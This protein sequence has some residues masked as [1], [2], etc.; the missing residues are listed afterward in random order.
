MGI[1]FQCEHCQHGLNLKSE[2]AGRRGICPKC[3]GKFRIPIDSITSSTDA[4]SALLES[5]ASSSGEGLSELLPAEA[6]DPPVSAGLYWVC[7]PSGGRYGPADVALLLEWAKQ[8]RITKDSLLVDITSQ[9]DSSDICSADTSN[10]VR[11]DILLADFYH[12]QSYR[13]PDY[14]KAKEPVIDLLGTRRTEARASLNNPSSQ[15]PSALVAIRNKR[16]KEKNRN[17]VIICLMIAIAILLCVALVTV[18]NRK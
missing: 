18:L 6:S 11:A 10:G 15:S 12:H 17:L 16:T 1:R 14:S 4:D 13:L 8:D 7:P 3:K 2:L 9:A 5:E